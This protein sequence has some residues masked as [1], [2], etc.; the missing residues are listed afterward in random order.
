MK[1]GGGGGAV[2][3]DTVKDR[4]AVA[5]RKSALPTC[6]ARS[7]QV[8][9]VSSVAMLPL[10]WQTESVSDEK[11]TGNPDVALALSCIGG[12]V[13]KWSP[14]DQNAMRWVASVTGKLWS[15]FDAA[16]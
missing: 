11:V 14:T 1:V 7:V 2:K 3:K 6:D 4:S 8:P 13:M 10:T 9:E 5:D 12:S 15:T 16:A